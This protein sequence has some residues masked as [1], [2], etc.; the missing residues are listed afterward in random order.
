MP[1]EI[2]REE[3][4]RMVGAAAQLVEVLPAEELRDLAL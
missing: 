1:T 3:L 2:G 4:R